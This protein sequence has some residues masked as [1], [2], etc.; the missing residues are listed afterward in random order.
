MDVVTAFLAGEM[1]EEI[2]MEQPEGFEAGED[3]VCLL[4]KSLY[5]LKQAAR[6]WN[7]KIRGYLLSIGFSQ[8]H[9]DH[10]VYI[11]KDTGVII[12]MWV[13]DL[14]IFRKDINSIDNLKQQLRQEFEMKDLGE[15]KYFLGMQIHRDRSQ[16]L[17]HI[18]QSGYINSILERRFNMQNSNTVPTPLA[19][20]T[21]L[22]KPT[23]ED[24]LTDP[25]PYQQKWAVKC[26][27]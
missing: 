5:E 14:L 18:N 11:N 1:D 8:L 19:A 25:K 4:M 13:D 26:T 23:M 21:K 27:P 20:G 9:S 15:L 12:A 3:Q 17:L 22:I 2:Y 7:Q 16:K 10:C 6:V 24:V